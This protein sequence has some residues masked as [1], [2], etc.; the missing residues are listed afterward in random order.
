MLKLIYKCHLLLYIKL[1]QRGSNRENIQCVTSL[2]LDAITFST[3]AIMNN[4][5]FPRQLSKVKVTVNSNLN[6]IGLTAVF[7]P[8]LFV[9][10]ILKM[11]LK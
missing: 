8:L 7:T 11:I 4:E 9:Y 3:F 2:N 1:K 10:L 5:N 6:S